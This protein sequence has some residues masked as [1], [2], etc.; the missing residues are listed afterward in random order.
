[1]FKLYAQN[2]VQLLPP[3]LSDMIEKDH[4]ARLISSVVDEMDISA[5][6][7]S[8]SSQGC[9]AYHPAMLL[10]VLVYAYSIG[11]RSSRKIADRLQEDIVFMRLSG[12]STPDFRT[13]ALFRKDRMTDFKAVFVQVVSLC[14]ELGMARVGTI[15]IDG[16]KFTAN[17]SRNRVVYRKNLERRKQSI[18]EKIDAII[19][20]ADELDRQ[21]DA[22]YGDTTAHHTGISFDKETIRK[23]LGKI[24]KKKT[25]LGKKKET[26]KAI[27]DDIKKKERIMRKDRNSYA[28][29]DKDATVMLMKEE[30]IAPGYNAQLATENQVVLAYGLFPNRTDYKL[31]K[32]MI[33]EVE[34]MTGLTPK[35]VAADAGYGMK[36]NYRFLKHKRIT[37]FIP[38]QNY[39][40]DVVLKHKGLYALPKNPDVELEK[41]K[42]RMFIR[43]G[44]E[45]GKKMMKRRREDVEPVFGDMKEHMKFRR[46]TLRGK[47]KCLIELGILSFAHNIKKIKTFIQ[48]RIQQDIITEDIEKWGQILGYAHS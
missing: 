25:S 8:Y 36:S 24:Q 34:N 41:Y 1:M 44:S 18:A 7:R 22:L 33:A 23:A 27:Q 31:L 48:S 6:E 45:E 9:R 37:G 29:A 26:L 16:T 15:S 21:E 3:N 39:N 47:P 2:Q 46:F 40:R 4:A 20:E 5:I 42:A 11:L 35:R 17:T 19:D 38:Y 10:K 12:R 13:I 28:V 32:P 14:M 30:Y 43:L